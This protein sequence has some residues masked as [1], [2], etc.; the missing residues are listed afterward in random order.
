MEWVKDG[1]ESFCAR[2]NKSISEVRLFDAVSREG[3]IK[4]CEECAK[5]EGVPIIRKPNTLQLKDSEKSY[6][7]YERLARA[8]GLQDRIHK[9]KITR[10]RKF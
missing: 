9:N 5:L 6:T 2:C 10:C 7:V 1:P 3:I 4:M 8:A